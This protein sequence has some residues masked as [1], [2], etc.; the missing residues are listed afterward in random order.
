MM[1]NM[2]PLS[3]LTLVTL[4]TCAQWGVANYP[5]GPVNQNRRFDPA[6]PVNTGVTDPDQQQT[7]AGRGQQAVGSTNMKHTH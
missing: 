1:L 3:S 2:L 5:H 7:I 4:A 6:V